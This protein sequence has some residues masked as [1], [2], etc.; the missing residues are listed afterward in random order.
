MSAPASPAPSA[1]APP[2]CV[3]VHER[4]LPGPA[5]A[6]IAMTGPSGSGKSTLLHLMA[7]LDT[8]TAGIGALAGARRLRPRRSRPDRHGVP[9]PQ[10]APSP[11]RDRERRA[12]AAVR[13]EAS[14][15]RP[16]S[17]PS[18]ALDLVDIGELAAKLPEELSGG[19]AQRVAIARVLAAR[20]AADPGR[21][22]HRADSTT[23]PRSWSST[24]CW[25]PR[26]RSVPR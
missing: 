17:T 14:P 5:R 10:P 22:T 9:R 4:Q 3:A 18:A 7:G 11:R 25:T 15:M 12:A 26:T 24:C 13:R 8:P 6:R 16:C 19:Q 1:P 21:R 23:P 2:P 20:P